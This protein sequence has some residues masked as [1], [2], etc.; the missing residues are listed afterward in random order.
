MI[1]RNF[2]ILTVTLILLTGLVSCDDDDFENK[3]RISSYNSSDSHKTGQNCMD[4][5]KPGGSGESVFTIAGTVYDS[6]LMSVLPG[7][8]I[9][10]YT[11]S[12]GAGTLSATIQVDKF[13]NFYTTEYVDFENGL[14]ASAEG[15]LTTKFMNST[16]MTG[17][18][19]SCHGVTTDRMWTR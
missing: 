5:H 14:Y 16:V 1:R 7:A 15:D 12:N 11:D 18:C 10:L 13:G 6:T 4:C 19:N 17:E 9:K 3:T 8:T 2:N